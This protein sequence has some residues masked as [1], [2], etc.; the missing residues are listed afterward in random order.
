MKLQMNLEDYF[1][2][3]A[4]LGNEKTV[5]I[6]DRGVMDLQ[7]FG[8]PENWEEI[9]AENDWTVAN[10]RDRRYDAVIH[11]VTS[12]EGAPDYYKSRHAGIS[13]EIVIKYKFSSHIH[14]NLL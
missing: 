4:Y 7:F 3:L 11:L 13:G 1:T 14:F 6:C 8:P 9:L 10:L 2:S 5:I 12:A